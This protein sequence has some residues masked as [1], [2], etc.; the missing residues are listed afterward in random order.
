VKKVMRKNPGFPE[1]GKLSP[2]RLNQRILRYCGSSRKE[3]LVGPLVGEDAAVIEF[4]PG[5]LLVVSSDPVVGAQEGAGT[6]LVHINVND[7]ASKGAD[8]AYLLVTMIF[9]KNTP[10]EQAEILMREI[11]NI[12]SSMGIAVVGGHTEFS[13]RYDAP[14]LSATLLGIAD[15]CLSMSKVCP[16]DCILMTK[17]AGLEGMS[18]LAKD[19]RDL[20][21]FFTSSEIEEIVH[22]S[23]DLSVLPESKII[24]G[25]A[26]FMH[27]PTEGGVLGGLGE[28][29]MLSPYA[30]EIFPEAIPCHALTKKA[31]E[32]LDF[33]PLHLI[34]SGALLGVVPLEF[35][36][37]VMGNLEKQGISSEIIGKIV[38]GPP[39]KMPLFSSKEEL[40][41]LLR[42]SGSD[43]F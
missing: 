23:K 4:P 24:R 12:C 5:K 9:P 29:A 18:I 32:M 1:T 13:D 36:E 22:W 37:E 27:D 15:S 6:L 10:E 30:L 42:L 34:S 26:R 41:R 21:S 8:P 11:D 19:R 38:D 31:A 35:C 20:L 14:V 43:S 3:V 17:H 40:W 25:Y 28:I 33:D 2:E 39:K 7:I 16:G